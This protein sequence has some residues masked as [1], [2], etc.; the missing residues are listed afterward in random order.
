MATRATVTFKTPKET[1]TYYHHWDGYPTH[2]G[3]E[4]FNMVDKH[5]DE[6]NPGLLSYFTEHLSRQYKPMD[7]KDIKNTGEEYHY[8]VTFHE[9]KPGETEN[10]SPIVT[11]ECEAWDSKS[12]YEK[13]DRWFPKETI[14]QWNAIE[15][16]GKTA[17]YLKKLHLEN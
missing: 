10:H 8:T 15:F 2:L 17:A 4:L 13:N 14:A 12:V 5:Y 7:E 6:E 16:A 3:L 1:E 9:F 11:I